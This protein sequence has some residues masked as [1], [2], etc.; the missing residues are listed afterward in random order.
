V[1]AGRSSEPRLCGSSEYGNTSVTRYQVAHSRSYIDPYS[2]A[3]AALITPIVT[4]AKIPSEH[5]SPAGLVLHGMR[6]AARAAVSRAFAP[7]KPTSAAAAIAPDYTTTLSY[8]TPFADFVSAPVAFEQAQKHT[9]ATASAVREEVTSLAAGYLS[10]ASPESDFS[11]PSEAEI[12][13]SIAAAKNVDVQY[14]FS[15]PFQDFCHTSNQMSGLYEAPAEPLHISFASPETD[16]C[17]VPMPVV[18]SPPA[19]LYSFASPESDFSAA[20]LLFPVSAAAN[21]ARSVYHPLPMDLVRALSS[22]DAVVITESHS[23]FR[24]THVNHAW[25]GLCGF[26]SSE[27]VGKTLEILHGPKTSGRD[28]RSLGEKCS[29]LTHPH[30]STTVI[31]AN[32]NKAGAL[33]KNR[34]TVSPL[35]NESGQVT[36][37]MGRLVSMGHR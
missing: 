15:S 3:R 4:D 30:Q 35:L 14:S 23:P 27:A 13:L 24:I 26:T 21:L 10:F 22:P 1:W 11:A 6:F 5:I 16:V 20:N 17:A 12:E 29:K 34:L 7:T 28:L 9:L 18:A 25:E 31:L 37:L 2:N 36:H 32:Y 8:A 33:F 19:C